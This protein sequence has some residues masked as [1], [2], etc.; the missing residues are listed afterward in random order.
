MAEPL[1]ADSKSLFEYKFFCFN[2]EPKIYQTCID[3]DKSKG[4]AELT[5]YDLNGEKLPIK[6]KNH[7]RKSTID[8]PVP[9]NLELMLWVC[10]EL[11]KDTFFLRVDFYEVNE[12]IYCG[13]LTFFE[14][15][16]FCEFAPDE[17]NRILGDWIK[18]PTD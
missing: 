17:W 13:E 2:G 11:S 1:I 5:F 7:S 15:A 16:G 10:R 4:G 14:S 18:L 9:H 3:R 12:K 6:D 8:V